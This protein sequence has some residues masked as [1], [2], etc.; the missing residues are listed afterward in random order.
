MFGDNVWR[1][2]VPSP[3]TAFQPSSPPLLAPASPRSDISEQWQADDTTT[4]AMY[5]EDTD[6]AFMAPSDMIPRD[7]AE[8][9]KLIVHACSPDGTKLLFGQFMFKR[10]P[11]LNGC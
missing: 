4:V 5:D 9:D 11:R 10:K 3:S 2:G 6:E 8:H 1:P 7:Q